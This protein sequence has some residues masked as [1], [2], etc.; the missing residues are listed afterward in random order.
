[1]T[2]AEL[3]AIRRRWAAATPGPWTYEGRGWISL[4][5]PKHG[6]PRERLWRD[7]DAEAIAAA[8]ADV[9]ALLTALDEQAAELARLRRV[10]AAA[11]SLCDAVRDAGHKD[12]F[13]IAVL[14]AVL[15]GGDRE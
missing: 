4:G 12:G 8:P 11:R 3:E 13:A 1:M 7:T 9:A 14:R 15:D 6:T 10:E 2:P 5:P